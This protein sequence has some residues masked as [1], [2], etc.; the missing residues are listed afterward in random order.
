MY[1]SAWLVLSALTLLWTG[2]LLFLATRTDTDVAGV[3]TLAGIVGV[4]LWLVWSY[5]ALQIQVPSD[6]TS[7]EIVYSHPELALVGLLVAWLPA[8]LA[9]TGPFELVK[10]YRSGDIDE[11]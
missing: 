11:V 7:T 5:S 9:F 1:V 2:A 3:T 4:I 10:R 8:Y 6:D